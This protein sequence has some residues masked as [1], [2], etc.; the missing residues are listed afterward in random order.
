MNN[1][2]IQ[3]AER[4]YKE[5]HLLKYTNIPGKKIKHKSVWNLMNILPSLPGIEL[6]YHTKM[7]K[8]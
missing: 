5:E 7:I 2:L 4:D 6:Y 3:L 1:L 8:N